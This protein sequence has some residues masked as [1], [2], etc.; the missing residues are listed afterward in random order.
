MDKIYV[1]F[2]ALSLLCAAANGSVGT[3]TGAL[4][5]GAGQGITLALS[6]AGPMCLWCGVSRLMEESGASE[7]LSRLLSPILSDSFRRP[8]MTGDPGCPECQRVGQFA[9]TGQRRNAHG[10]PGG[11]T[12]G[13]RTSGGFRRAVPLGGAEYGL[14]AADSATV[15]GIRAGLGSAAP[16]DILPAVWVTSLCS[17][18]AGLLAAKVLSRWY[19]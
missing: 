19:S 10:D 12:D 15:A 8:G 9:G 7:K 18:A 2:L 13:R 6:I 3:L 14:G 17:V 5:E 4:L 16:L 1:L 11:G